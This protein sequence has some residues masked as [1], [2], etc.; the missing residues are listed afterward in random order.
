[1]DT[2]T[3]ERR[4]TLSS[5][6][7]AEFPLFGSTKLKSITSYLNTRFDRQ[8]DVDGSAVP[9]LASRFRDY[10]N[11]T[12]GQELRLTGSSDRLDWFVGGSFF[13]ESVRQTVEL[14]YSENALLGSTVIPADTFFAGQPAFA[15]CSEPLTTAV[16][17][18]GCSDTALENISGRARN[19]SYAVFGEINY[20]SRPGTTTTIN[21]PKV[22]SYG[23]EVEADWKL[24]DAIQLEGNLALN[25]ATFR[26]LVSGGIDLSGNRL[27]YSPTLTGFAAANWRMLGNADGSLTLRGSIRHES[28]QF[29]SKENLIAESDSGFTL[30][31]G[32][33]VAQFNNPNLS[34]RIFGQNLF[35]K[36]YL[37]YAVNQGFGVVANRGRP[38]TIG[39][40]LRISY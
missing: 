35:G 28:R 20:R 40:E 11:E 33:L 15:A 38:R 3:F 1:M 9:L 22:R 10:R 5:A 24:S 18:L 4:R 8:F 14:T 13:G 12:F 30:V 6:L 26:S 25:S 7:I 21:A 32:A 16:F 2:P 36:N 17:G 31:D 39:A 34:L 29:F 19:R 27:L 23:A 37:I